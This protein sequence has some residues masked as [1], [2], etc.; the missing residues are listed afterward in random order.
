MFTGF[1]TKDVP[2]Y[3][4]SNNAKKK[5]NLCQSNLCCQINHKTSSK[6]SSA[7][8]ASLHDIIA[9]IMLIVQTNGLLVANVAKNQAAVRF[10]QTAE[11]TFSWAGAITNITRNLPTFIGFVNQTKPTF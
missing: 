2:D 5:R 1:F 8:T 10:E 9:A 3:S 11:K 4:Q 7:Q 6:I